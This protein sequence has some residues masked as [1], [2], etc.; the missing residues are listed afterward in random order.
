LSAIELHRKITVTIDRKMGVCIGGTT[1]MALALGVAALVQLSRVSAELDTAVNSTT[2]KIE[3]VGEIK[4]AAFG[5]RLAERGQLLFSS[6]HAE[7]KI[8]SSHEAFGKSADAAI[9]KIAELRPLLVLPRGL[10]LAGQMEAGIA[11]YRSEQ[12]HVWSMLQQNKVAEAIQWDSDHL[13]SIGGGVTKNA[14]GLLT[15]EK[16]INSAA[17]T[18]TAAIRSQAKWIVLALLAGSLVLAGV[19]FR[20]LAGITRTLRKVAGG[21]KGGAREIDAAATQVSAATATLSEQSSNQAMSVEETAAT[22]QE[23]S[24]IAQRNKQAADEAAGLLGQADE[25]D[26]RIQGAV[27]SLVESVDEINNSSEQVQKVVRVIDEIAFQTNILALNAAV[28]AARAGESGMGFAVV[29]DEVRN[30]AQRSAQ[31]AK[32]TQTLIERSVASA[33]EGRQRV[34]HVTRAFSESTN[35]RTELRRRSEEIAAASSEQSHGL[36]QIASAIESMANS[37]QQTAAQAEEGAAASE[38][39]KSQAASLS[40]MAQSLEDLVVV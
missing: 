20:V 26:R 15:L 30:L 25:V 13:F 24:S 17:V 16:E 8:L 27:N 9:A 22:S 3:L 11:N 23:I 10:E 4:A 29:A 12:E 28:E 14:D 6:I 40:A 38:E 31:A 2:R 19:V 1:L 34:D 36:A 5:F 39:L 37:A 35:I 7:D 32:E 18:R 21:V 33:R